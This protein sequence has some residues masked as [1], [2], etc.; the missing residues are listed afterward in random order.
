VPVR[1]ALVGAVFLVFVG[2][3][4]GVGSSCDE[5]E[6]RCLDGQR[7]LVCQSEHF[8]ETP[9]RGPNGCRAEAKGTACDVRANKTGDSCSSDE[10]GA[11]VCADANTLVACRRG[12]YVR[13]ACRGKKGC[14]EENGHALCDAT[15]AE[16]AEACAEE[17]RKACSVDGKQVL[18]CSEGQMQPRYECRGARGCAVTSG[19]IDCDQSVAALRDGCDVSSEGSFA[20]AEDA[21]SLVRCTGGSFIADEICKHGQLCV[22]EAG[23]MRCAKPQK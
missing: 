7:A 10:E 15:V 1:G 17:E 19:K 8:I 4:P 9:C 16:R 12:A 13:A 6:A 14:V 18:A 23:G 5:G 22:A 20:C 3:K 21:K 11:A 2:C